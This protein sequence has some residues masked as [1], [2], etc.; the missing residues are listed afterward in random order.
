MTA[1][2]TANSSA[3]KQSSWPKDYTQ[4]KLFFHHEA[5]HMFMN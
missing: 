2:K 1:L 4:Q 5:G 3:V